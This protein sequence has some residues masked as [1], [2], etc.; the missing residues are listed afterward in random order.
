[1]TRKCA[2]PGCAREPLANDIRC[3]ECR[4]AQWTLR[5]PEWVKRARANALPA[6]ELAA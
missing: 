2:T 4:W 3:R 6:K 1:M 5:E